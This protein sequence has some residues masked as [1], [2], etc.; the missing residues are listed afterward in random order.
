MSFVFVIA[1]V[2]NF[3]FCHEIT[4]SDDSAA[5]CGL[6]SHFAYYSTNYRR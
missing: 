3:I 4:S 1:V 6:R 2:L 5:S